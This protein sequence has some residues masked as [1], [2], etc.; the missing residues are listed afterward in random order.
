MQTEWLD[1]SSDALEMAAMLAGI[2]GKSSILQIRPKDEG[3]L[4]QAET[5]PFGDGRVGWSVGTGPLVLLVHGY[6]GRGTQMA[7]LAHAIAEHGFRAVY[8]DAGGHGSSQP[9][10]VGFSTFIADT[11]AIVRH[12]NVPVFAMVG[13]S[14]GGLAMMR[15]RELHGISAERYVLIAAPLFPYPAL[16]TMF[17][18][19]ATLEAL[20][21]VK[22]MLADQFQTNWSALVKGSAYIPE[23]GKSLLAIYDSGD[24]QVRHTDAER[25]AGIWSGALVLNTRG[26]GHNRVLQA[27]ETLRAVTAFL[28]SD[29]VP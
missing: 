20:D 10:K 27:P 16:E 26:Y 7:A 4:A 18:R 6:S 28:S 8:F 22:A 21:Y 23:Q 15:A 24:K 5:F 13:H 19:G 29:Q 11:R 3:F 17:S 12:L 14:A 2:L 1:S 9:E 25:L